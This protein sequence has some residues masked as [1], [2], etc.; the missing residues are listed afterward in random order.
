MNRIEIVGFAKSL[1]ALVKNKLYD[2][3]E[4]ILDA[5]LEEAQLEK[6]REGRKEE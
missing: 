2:D 6:K 3:V 1:K 5:V 4:D